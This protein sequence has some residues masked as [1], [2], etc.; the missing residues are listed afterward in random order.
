MTTKQAIRVYVFVHDDLTDH[1]SEQLFNDYFKWLEK[2]LE[3]ISG[4][5]VTIIVRHDLESKKLTAF[6]YKNQSEGT[7]LDQW[8]KLL[9]AELYKN[10][11]ILASRST[12]DKYLLLTRDNINDTTG[13]IA[14]STLH[15]GIASIV[16]YQIAA[17]EIGHLLG[18][19]HED[20]EVLYNGW[21]SET[22][23]L[24]DENSGLRAKAYRFSDKNRESIR[25]YLNKLP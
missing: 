14:F 8:A 18:A 11:R 7:S 2:E 17:H 9:E 20:S 23:M 22:I 13:G 6:H 15:T 3:M 4:R 24:T 16:H 1:T 21:W 10:W 5:R 19:T 12:H 25:H